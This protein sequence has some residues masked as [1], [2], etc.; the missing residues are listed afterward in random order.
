MR[1]PGRPSS[2]SLVGVAVLMFVCFLSRSV[3]QV[4][5]AGLSGTISDPSGAVIPGIHVVVCMPDTG[6][7]RET[8]ASRA[9][10]YEVPQLPV[11]IYTVTLTGKGFAT[12]IFNHVILP[13]ESLDPNSRSTSPA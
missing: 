3:A 5:H 10:T 2:I 4:D 7:V 9:G 13:C 1:V 12:L 8:D 11:G 6:S